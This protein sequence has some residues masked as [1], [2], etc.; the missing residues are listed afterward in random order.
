MPRPA[1]R[2]APPRRSPSVVV[3]CLLLLA[4]LGPGCDS[5]SG[6]DTSDAG[7]DT[8]GEV[9]PVRVGFGEPCAADGD[10]LSNACFE[11]HCT[12]AC[13]W[14][15]ACPEDGYAC[16]D[17]GDGRTLCV[18][19]RVPMRD[20][21]P[22]DG[23]SCVGAAC[24]EA[25]GFRCLRTM[26]DDPYAYCTHACTDDRDCP[27]RMTCRTGEDG[28][29]CRQRSYCEPCVLDDQC[30]YANDDC[31]A[32]ESGTKFCSQACDPE[33]ATT[34]PQDST[35][36]ETVAGRWQCVP[37]F[38]RCVGDGE[39]CHPCR[40]GADCDAG[41]V[42]LTD[43]YT[44]FS[45]CGSPCTSSDQCPVQ[46][47]CAS[48]VHLCRPRRGSCSSPSGG[49][50]TCNSCDDFSDCYDG[51]CLDING[52]G[53]GDACGSACDPRASD[54]CGPYGTCY[55]IT[56]GGGATLGHNCFPREGMVC[57]QYN[58]CMAECPD[59]PTGCSLSTCR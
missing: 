31:V 11:G 52:D 41:N 37:D 56:D 38:G 47:Y 26:A 21:A 27:Y 7:T 45:F 22:I 19:T 13:A 25:L 8:T 9:P 3:P 18:T 17:A 24:P 59:G 54:P 10:C 33:R 50:T 32:D 55:A 14:E 35:C 29:F 2:T 12:R 4:I 5:D 20:G 42:C 51:F 43:R 28:R 44:G 46:F 58:Q 30:G 15:S 23:T 34:C 1:H 40:D 36:T 49:G 16:G 57:W 6:D 39:L 53:R 48:D